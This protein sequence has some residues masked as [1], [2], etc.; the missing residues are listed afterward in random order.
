MTIDELA[1]SFEKE[2]DFNCN[3]RQFIVDIVNNAIFNY[4]DVP[5]VERVKELDI[6]SRQMLVK[7]Y[8][9]GFVDLKKTRLYSSAWFLGESNLIG[10]QMMVERFSFAS[11][12][13][14]G[15]LSKSNLD[16][17]RVFSDDWCLYFL[18]DREFYDESD[19]EY[20]YKGIKIVST[21]DRY[22]EKPNGGT[23]HAPIIN[24]HH[25]IFDGNFDSFSEFVIL[26][27]FA[28]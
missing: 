28:L 10:P 1:N 5:S 26:N 18:T 23:A 7:I 11:A 3:Y 6:I 8:P 20:L 15:G 17:Y 24:A 12:A 27:K 4:S 16:F 25:F 21:N 2:L 9:G 19:M 22:F 14:Y 13:V